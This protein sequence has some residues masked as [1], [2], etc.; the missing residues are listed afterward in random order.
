MALG[1]HHL[2][3]LNQLKQLLGNQSNKSLDFDSTA[4]NILGVIQKS[5]HFDSA[6]IIKVSPDSLNIQ[7]IF[8]HHFSQK[9]FSKYLDDYYTKAPI[10]TLRQIKN[11]GFISKKGSE[12]V[13]EELWISNPFY[14]EIIKPLGLNFFVS[15]ACINTRQEYIGYI[16][17]WRSTDRND[18]SSQDCFFLE[19][20]SA[21]TAELLNQAK[22]DEDK[23]IEKPEVLK[24]VNQRSNPGVII[25]GQG[26]RIIFINQ[27][28]KNILNIIKSG[29]A[30]LSNKNDDKFM[31]KL[32]NLKEKSL[33]KLSAEGQNLDPKDLCNVF[34]FRGTIYTCRGIPLDGNPLHEGSVMILIETVHEKSS[35]ISLS[36]ENSSGFTAREKAIADLIR[37]GMTSKEIASDLGI[38]IHTVKDHIKNIMGK[39]KT[40]TR[41]GIVSKLIFK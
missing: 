20:A 28:A 30:Y 19:K 10:P 37:Q 17:L 29:K 35:S 18:F 3:T 16:V 11:E 36:H 13:E 33:Q 5:I 7:D 14:Q 27:E 15:A 39:L 31:Q 25:L 40:R 24:L 9:A 38:G 1:K 4:K 2:L 12:L 21:D 8:L 22:K 34:N 32:Y 23:E 6:W 41:S 26:N